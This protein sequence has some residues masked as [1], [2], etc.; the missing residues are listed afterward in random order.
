MAPLLVPARHRAR[1]LVSATAHRSP[2][3]RK[4]KAAE[5][6]RALQ[7]AVWAA[8]EE[9]RPR[10]RSPRTAAAARAGT[11]R[12]PAAAAAVATAVRAVAW[13]RTPWPPSSRLQPVT[14]TPSRVA[15]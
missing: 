11:H 6:L 13:A 10:R 3:A 4:H 8:R 5:V 15:Q 7:V 14:V 9:W 12:R 1:S 2:S